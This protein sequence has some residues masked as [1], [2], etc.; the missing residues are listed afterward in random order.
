MK[1]YTKIK[2]AHVWKK[3]FLQIIRWKAYLNTKKQNQ[4]EEMQGY[5][6]RQGMG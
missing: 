3:L 6:N 1:R 2:S 4:F 5:T